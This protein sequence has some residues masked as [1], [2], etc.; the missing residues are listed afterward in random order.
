M[1]NFKEIESE[2]KLYL[3][4]YSLKDIKMKDYRILLNKALN[5]IV[6]SQEKSKNKRIKLKKEII[7]D[8]IDN[9][10][11]FFEK[12]IVDDFDLKN[13]I[14]EEEISL[15]LNQK[16]LLFKYF[17]EEIDIE[18]ELFAFKVKQQKEE[19]QVEAKELINR[20]LEEFYLDH[21]VRL[22]KRKI[23]FNV[24]PTNSG[25]SYNALIKFKESK[26][27]CYLAPLRLLAWEVYEKF[28][29]EIPISL[30]TGE[31]KE[32]REGGTHTSSTI[33]MADY[34]TEYEIGIIDEI[35]MMG[36]AERGWS[37]TKSLLL[38]NAETIYLCG[39]S[40]V[41][42][43]L[44]KII[45]ITGD[46]LEIVQH[47]RKTKLNFIN[48]VLNFSNL[49]K[50]DALVTFSRKNIFLL[51]DILENEYGRTVSV[52]YGML[53]PEVRKEEA[54]RFANGETE[55]LIATDAI[56]MGLN[57]PIK[58]VIFSTLEKYYNKKSH[59]ISI[60]EVKQI[61]GRAGRYGLHEEGEFG[62]LD[63]AHNPSNRF[64]FYSKEDINSDNRFFSSYLKKSLNVSVPVREEAYLGPDYDNYVLINDK[65][66]SKD[67][68]KISLLEFYYFFEELTYKHDFFKKANIE[69]QIE[70][71]EII[72]YLVKSGFILDKDL[73]KLSVAPVILQNEEHL[74]FFKDLVVSYTG[75]DEMDLKY[76]KKYLYGD[77]EDLEV[78]YKQ[79]DLY[80]WLKNQLSNKN[81]F[82]ETNDE[83]TQ[84]KNILNEK[85]IKQLKF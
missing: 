36:D 71:T 34:S 76:L 50:G 75:E 54:D 13:K 42:D 11:A 65:L 2:I 22:K 68:L 32:I 40:S 16:K 6:N 41:L 33:E 82:T 57:L 25:K 83:L 60:S 51:K 23:I 70:Q 17:K 10:K 79:L 43:L 26:K 27:A 37:W 4:K 53:S 5:E 38:L 63:Q 55:I 74:D 58:R 3:N 9:N 31:E 18:K 28:K 61:S 66:K 56:G 7:L 45:K 85:I 12:L 81:L 78:K 52:V 20:Y 35:Q 21:P 46:E 24:G 77:L 47:E 84:F 64:K 14:K 72:N 29:N 1:Q 73:F 67:L 8:F 49:K 19:R 30:I 59:L 69:N 80:K 44:K 39:D 62:L 48:K 15:F